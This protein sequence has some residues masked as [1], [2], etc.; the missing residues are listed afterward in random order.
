MHIDH[1]SFGKIIIDGKTYS[2]DVILYPDR[3]DS[4]W[5]RKEGH[6]LQKADLAGIIAANPDLLIVGT[7]AYGVMAVPESTI[8]FLESQN[9]S[10]LIERTDN[11]VELFNK[12]PQG[13]KVIAA[14]HLTC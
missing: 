13:K 3:I 7:G 9:V 14:L 2:S 8:A 6:Y 12:Q 5:W 10:V 11:A 4:S 1:Y